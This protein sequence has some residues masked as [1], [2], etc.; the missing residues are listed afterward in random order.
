MTATHAKGE[1]PILLAFSGGLDTSFCVP[2]LKDTYERPVITVSFERRQYD[3]PVSEHGVWAFVKVATDPA[4]SG[5]PTL[6]G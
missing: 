4:R 2:W 5:P 1:E 6:A 3:V